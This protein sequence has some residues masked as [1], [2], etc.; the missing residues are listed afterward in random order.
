[1]LLSTT[2]P[3]G[4]DSGIQPKETS[5][6]T[7]LPRPPFAFTVPS[8]SGCPFRVSS[9]SRWLFSVTPFWVTTTWR[10]AAAP[11]VVRH[12]YADVEAGN[13]TCIFLVH[14]SFTD[15]NKP[16]LT[17]SIA[18]IG[19]GTCMICLVMWEV[20]YSTFHLTIH[21]ISACCVVFITPPD[22]RG[23]F[24]AGGPDRPRLPPCFSGYCM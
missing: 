19:K 4:V 6:F 7:S 11:T 21:N 18:M 23:R 2:R 22:T 8:F 20:E 3:S 9:V 14:N 10:S 5:V 12:G 16:Q 13:W 1:M 17:I 24:A 15:R